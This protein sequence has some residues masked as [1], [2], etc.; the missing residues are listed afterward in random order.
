MC[1]VN[2]CHKLCVYYVTCVS[3]V[4]L[5]V[6]LLLLCV[7]GDSGEPLVSMDNKDWYV[8]FVVYYVSMLYVVYA[9]Y[10]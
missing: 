8:I 5:Y 4:T 3:C 6:S 1:C 7:A 2:L 9:F 10:V